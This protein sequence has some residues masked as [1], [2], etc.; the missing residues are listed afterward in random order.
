MVRKI[1]LIHLPVKY[2]LLGVAVAAAAT[3]DFFS[4]VHVHCFSFNIMGAE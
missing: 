4:L 2:V 3:I 1:E